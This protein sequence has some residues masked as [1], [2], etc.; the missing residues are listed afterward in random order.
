MKLFIIIDRFAKIAD[1]KDFNPIFYCNAGD[2]RFQLHKAAGRRAQLNVVC[3]YEQQQ[4]TTAC[5][6]A[7]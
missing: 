2:F 3:V 1:D 4:N 5:T 7:P 6:V